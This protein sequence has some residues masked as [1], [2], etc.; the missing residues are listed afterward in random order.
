MEEFQQNVSMY[1]RCDGNSVN[2]V[3]FPPNEKAARQQG[4]LFFFKGE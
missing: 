4:D 2:N 1:R 3:V